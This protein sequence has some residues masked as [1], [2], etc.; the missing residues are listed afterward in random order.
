MATTKVKKPSVGAK[1]ALPN[2]L[3]CDWDDVQVFRTG[4]REGPDALV[5]LCQRC[6]L[7]FIEPPY[8]DLR[9]YYRGKYRLT[10]D[11]VPGKVLTPEERFN[12]YRPLM[13]RRTEFFREHIPKGAMVL[14]IGCSSGYFL[15]TIQADYSVFGNEWNS[16]DAAFVRDI[17]EVPCEEG[18]IDDVYP[19]QQFTAIC[20]YHVLEHQ[21]D[22][23]AWLRK[24]K[25][26]LIG[27]GWLIL[28]L[29]NAEDALAGIYDIPAFRD[30]WYQE[31]HISYFS[32][33]NLAAAL[34][35]VGFEAKVSTRQEYGV[36]NHAQWLTKGEP[37]LDLHE[38]RS[39]ARPVPQ[40][41]PAE[42][43]LN[44]WWMQ[45]DQEYR[46]MLETIKAGN[47]LVGIGQ[48]REI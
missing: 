25:S 46:V 17:G 1:K 11:G 23:I 24:V 19:G 16:K 34:A 9:E 41:H 39:F 26:R 22:P 30:R 27:G 10:H 29:P 7:R 5:Y 43:I 42:G 48:R 31:S 28:E 45:K 8:A 33:S 4:I 44:R 3:L 35:F 12:L 21:P 47:S 37:M 38:A 20:A 36:L 13:A 2:C 14:E 18:D 6:Q 40:A 32:V 15:D